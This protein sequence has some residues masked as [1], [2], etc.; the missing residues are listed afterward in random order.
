VGPQSLR[1]ELIERASIR[2]RSPTERMQIPRTGEP[3]GSRPK[4]P[5]AV[6]RLSASL[7][8]GGSPVQISTVAPRGPGSLATISA[9]TKASSR[10]Q[11]RANARCAG[12]QRRGVRTTR[13]DRPQD[14]RSSAR[15][16]AA[17]SCGH[18]RPPP[19]IVTTRTSLCMRRVAGEDA[20]DLPDTPSGIFFARHLDRGDLIESADKTGFWAQGPDDTVRGCLAPDSV[21]ACSALIA[22]LEND[23]WG[24]PAELT[25]VRARS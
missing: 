22:S 9:R 8:P 15:T 12:H 14:H 24:A 13:L 20:G 23:R 16:R 6:A 25:S 11:E 18:C 10:P 3:A 5:E 19:R 7:E 21:A 2:A 4:P 17:R 1:C